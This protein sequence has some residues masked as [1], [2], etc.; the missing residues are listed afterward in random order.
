MTGALVARALAALTLLQLVGCGER[1]E[2]DERKDISYSVREPGSAAAPTNEESIY[3]ITL[4]G[5]TRFA[6]FQALITQSGG[7]CDAVTAGVLIG[8]LD[9]TDEWRVKCTPAGTWQIWIKPAGPPEIVPCSS[10]NCS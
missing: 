4:D 5:P 8:G 1:S 2:P 7:R 9:Q 10:S 3:L 6:K